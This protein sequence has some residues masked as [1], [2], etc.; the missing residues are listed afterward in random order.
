MYN[1]EQFNQHNNIIETSDDM[2]RVKG[3]INLKWY[4]YPFYFSMICIYSYIATIFTNCSFWITPISWFV[5]ILIF[6]IWHVQAHHR[7]DWIPFNKS[8]HN[9]HN[10]HHQKYFPAKHFYGSVHASEWIKNYSNELYLVIHSLPLGELKPLESI[11]NESFGLI[12]LTIITFIKYFIIGLSLDI[13]IITII[14]GLLVDFIG[15]YLHLSF[16][17]P[18][19]WLN[20][21]E[22]YKELKYLHYEH[23]KDDTKRNYAIFFFGVDKMFETYVREYNKNINK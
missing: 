21:Y 23:H 4:G 5:D 13:I 7:I 17:I 19:H 8:C 2:F 14:Q 16:H 9:W 6:Y 11:Q 12:M 22:V 18:N 3:T 10:L 15:N 20:K 1:I